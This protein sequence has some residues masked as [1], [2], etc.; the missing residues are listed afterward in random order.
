MSRACGGAVNRT[1]RGPGIHGRR[2]GYVTPRVDDAVPAAP[3]RGHRHQ[4][5]QPQP[6]GARGLHGARVGG[7]VRNRPAA[8][9]GAARALSPPAGPSRRPRRRQRGGRGGRS[10]AGGRPGCLAPAA[11]GGPGEHVVEV[12]P[13][14][15]VAQTVEGVEPVL[16]GI[17]VPPQR[18]GR[19]RRGQAVSRGRRGAEAR[20]PVWP[21]GGG[22][23]GARPPDP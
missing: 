20:G 11:A 23:R 14:V 17:S 8:A 9:G 10:G 13:S 7:L 4:Q 21:A 22:R 15:A 3:G 19:R 18:R 16:A 5:R 12:I 1:C 6:P 2:V